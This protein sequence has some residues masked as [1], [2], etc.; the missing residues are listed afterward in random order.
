MSRVISFGASAPGIEDGADR[1]VGVLDR[2]L[3]LEARGHEELD[4]PA[5][6]LLEVAHALD[7]AL[8]H[9]HVSAHPERDHG[10]VVAD[11]A[12]SDDEHP[13]R[14]DARHASEEDPAAALRLLQVVGARLRGEPPGDLAH[15]RQQW[16]RAAVG[17]DRL[18]RDR[19]RTGLDERARQRLVGRD[20]EVREEREA[21]AEARILVRRSAP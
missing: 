18:V 17:L 20:V 11:H 9:R 16:E 6:D 7:G 8:E 12:A 21:R 2:L 13:R 15:G 14:R 5:Q 1:Q 4:A 19:R 3:D 10:R